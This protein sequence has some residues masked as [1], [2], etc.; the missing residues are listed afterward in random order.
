MAETGFALND[1]LAVQRWEEG[2]TYEAEVG[3][4]WSKFEGTGRDSLVVVKDELSK[5]RGE[6]VTFGLRAKL[7]GDGVEGDD[8]IEG[9]AAEEK[10]DFFNES[11][12]IDQRRKG[13]LSK[14]EMSQQRVTYDIRKECADALQVW[15]IED[16]DQQYFIYASGA[17]GINPDFHVGLAWTGRANNSL[18]VPNAANIIYGGNAT[19]KADLDSSDKMSLTI[20]ERLVAKAETQDPMIQPFMVEGEKKYVLLMHTWQKFDLRTSATDNDWLDITK[21]VQRGKEAQFYKNSLGEY[22]GVVMHSHRSVIRFSDYGAGG[23]VTAAR[24]LFLG[25]Q[26]MCCA[27]GRKVP[28]KNGA[29]VVSNIENRRV[30]WNEETAD[31][32]NKLAVTCGLISGVQK[33]RFNSKDFGIVAVDT[34]AKDPG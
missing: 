30:W 13:T 2:L 5:G 23:T 17:R 28:N 25:A 3:A 6:K 8:I 9:T 34:Y 29:S 11:L 20:I 15:F 27:Y 26:A 22:G 19:G 18:R 4:Y 12:F 7:S 1:P 21:A 16:R 32:G 33:T 24:A 10:V 31:R 14:G